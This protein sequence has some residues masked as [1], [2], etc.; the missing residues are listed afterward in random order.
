MSILAQKC[1]HLR[2][3]E[4]VRQSIP[5]PHFWIHQK[6]GEQ[7][8]KPN[9]GGEYFLFRLPEDD[10]S[11]CLALHLKATLDF[12]ASFNIGG[13]K[14]WFRLSCEFIKLWKENSIIM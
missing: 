4:D 2:N 6:K 9:G 13:Y 1:T 10:E 3:L 8:Q 12:I 7:Y 11:I 14:N 5:T